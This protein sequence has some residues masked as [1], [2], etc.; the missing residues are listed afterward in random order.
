MVYWQTIGWRGS[1]TCP[2]CRTAPYAEAR[3]DNDSD[4]LRYCD[5]QYVISVVSFFLCQGFY[6]TF[7][8]VGIGRRANTKVLVQNYWTD[9]FLMSV[10]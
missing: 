9:F 2:Y 1:Y 8:V 3:L 5:N 10:C 4:N 7:N 6:V